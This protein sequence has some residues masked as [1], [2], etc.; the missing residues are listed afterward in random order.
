MNS[1]ITNTFTKSIGN[2]SYTLS[3]WSSGDKQA[4]I[5]AWHHSP[6]GYDK[7]VLIYCGPLAGVM[8]KD[9]KAVFEQMLSKN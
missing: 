1:K 3:I 4:I 6:Y 2:A 8:D 9:D 5:Q 7:S